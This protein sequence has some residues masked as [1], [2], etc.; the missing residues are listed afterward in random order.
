MTTIFSSPSST[1]R[2]VR[3]RILPT[4]PAMNGQL[5]RRELRRLVAQMVG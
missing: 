5:S 1:I 4:R 2:K 3:E